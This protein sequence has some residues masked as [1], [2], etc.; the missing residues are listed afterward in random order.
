M[1]QNDI[2]HQSSCVDTPSQNGVTERKNWHLLE[3][4]RALL[5]QMKV[6]KHFWADAVSTACFLINRMLSSVLN[7]DIPYTALFF[8]KSL[9]PIEPR[10]FCCTCFVRDVRPQVT[11]LDPKSLKCVFLGYSLLQKWYSCFSPTLNHYLVSADVTFFE[12]T[13]FFPQSFVYESQGEEDDLLIYTVQPMSSPLPQ[14]V[15]SVSRPTRPP[16]VHVYSRRL[17]IS[18][19]D[20]PPA[21]SL[22]DPVPHTDHDS[23]LD[24]PIALRKDKR[25]CT[26]PIASFVSSNQL[27]SCSQCFVISLDSVPIPN[28]V[29][30]ALSHLGWCDAMKE[31]M[32]AL[33]GNGTWEL[34]PLP[35]GKKAIGCKWVFTVKV[36]PDDFVTRRKARLVAKGYAQTYGVDYSDTFSS[37]AKLTSIRLFISLAATYDR[38]LHQLDIKN[39]FLHGYLQEEVYMEQPPGF[40][41]QGELGKVCRLQMSL[42]GLKQSPRTWFG[43]FSEAVQEFGMQKSKCDHSVFYRQSEVGLIL[44]VVYV[45]DIV[46]TGSDSAGISSLK[47]FLQTQFQTKNLGLLKYFLGIEVMRSKKGIFLSQRKYVLD[48]LTETGKLGAKSCSAPMTPTLQLLAGDSELF[49]DPE[50]YRR[51]VGELNYLTVTR[52]DITYT[53]SVVSQFMSSST[54]AHWEAL[55]Q[56]LCYLKGAP[57]RCLLYG[58]HGHL[59]VECFSDADWA[60]SKVDRR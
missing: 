52:F 12:S 45:D 7:G 49:E 38:L 41:A 55:E 44:L 34:L 40:V 22:G 19:S 51:L 35:T 26:Y 13:P 39:A 8:T 18:D 37:V 28:T 58:N 20:P 47:T 4:T 9:F 14:P 2:L 59:N 54:V 24:L 29:G 33:D 6:P 50:R 53:V 31:E 17:E 15:S 10:I 3:V 25:S 36:N 46:I 21:T 5:F 1:I 11:K 42:Y 30:E 48:L 32:E 16:I 56:I 57:G 60:K 27:S 23:N 43:R